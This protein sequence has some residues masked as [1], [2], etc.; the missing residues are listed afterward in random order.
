MSRKSVGKCFFCKVD[1]FE[2][3]EKSNNWMKIPGT[4]NLS[5]IHHHGIEK[6]F[7]EDYWNKMIAQIK[8]EEAEEEPKEVKVV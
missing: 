6:L 4:K 7:D 3:K 2:E 8:K 5:C 1:L